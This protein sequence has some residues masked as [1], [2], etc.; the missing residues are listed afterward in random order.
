MDNK[1]ALPSAQAA[2]LLSDIHKSLHIGPKA[3]FRFLDPLFYLPGLR[4]A[5]SKAHMACQTCAS[6]TPQGGLRPRIPTHQMRGHQ[7]G[8]D[9]Q[10]DFTHMPRCKR[11][12]YLFTLVDT[13]SGWIE[14]YPT[15]QETA[16]TVTSI[17]LRH[18]IPQ[19]GLPTSIQS[20]NGPTFVSQVVQQVSKALHITW[21]LHIP[22]RPQ[23]SG[24]VERANG[25][26]K[27]HLTKLSLEVRVSWPELLHLALTRIRASPRGPTVLSPF[28]VLYGRPFLLHDLPT[29]S[30]PLASYL[31]YLSLLRHLLREHADRSLP[32]VAVSKA[33]S[34]PLQPGDSVLLKELHPQSLKPWWTGPH[35]VILTTPTAAKLL[36]HP[37]WYHV[38]RL[39]AA[40]TP[41]AGSAQPLGP[42]RLWLTRHPASPP[43]ASAASPTT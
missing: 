1:V 11:F 22:Y 5:I 18:I 32:T 40:P 14:A 21:K 29:Q 43:A 38:S 12:R 4:E 19:F 7:Q 10:V 6:V 20:D 17:L 39:K 34:L 27:D 23:S 26:L 8:E 2:S 37:S 35:T 16:D 24:K 13:F 42:T 9:W 25:I 36:G 31:P 33:L 28:E 15:A 41:E 3:M 30:P